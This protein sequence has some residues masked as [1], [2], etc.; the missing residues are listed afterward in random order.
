M[1]VYRVARDYLLK[2][3]EKN[4]RNVDEGAV[5]KFIELLEKAKT[6]GRRVFLIGA[7]R[8]GLVAKAVGMRLVHLDI[9]A[10]VVG[11]TIT[12]PLHKGDIVIAISGSGETTSVASVVKKA[13]ELG[14]VVVA[15]TS[16]PS[17]TI[18]KL[19]DIMIK[20]ESKR[21]EDDESNYLVRQI[22]ERKAPISPLGTLFELSAL[23]FLDSMISE[24]GAR[25]EMDE[26]DM[27]KRH[28]NIE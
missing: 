15:I 18:G 6:E 16:K 25:L 3:I 19:A 9:E 11:E 23:I 27:R 21:P 12:R 28:T 1:K 22:E 24:L 8:S 20:L 4:L 17:S 26:E 14:G 5:N 13:R 10:Y 2:S 7:G